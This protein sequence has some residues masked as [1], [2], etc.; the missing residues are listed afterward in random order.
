LTGFD[1]LRTDLI[2]GPDVAVGRKAGFL[3]VASEGPDSAAKPPFYREPEVGF[4]ARTGS[5]DGST[6]PAVLKKSGLG[7]SIVPRREDRADLLVSLPADADL[8]LGALRADSFEGDSH[9]AGFLTPLARRIR[10]M[11]SAV[12]L[13]ENY[14]AEELRALARRS[15]D[16]N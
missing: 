1:L 7:S 14:S 8:Y 5:S 3:R 16:A 10:A 2:V 4:T 6:G 11:P 13:R 9:G 12:K 15:K